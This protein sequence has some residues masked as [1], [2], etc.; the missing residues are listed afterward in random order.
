MNAN[1]ITK[2][3]VEIDSTLLDAIRSFPP[4]RTIAHCGETFTLSPFAFYAECPKCRL[5][6][7]VRSFAATPELEDVFDAVFEWM[8]DPQ[9][10][11]FAEQRR[12]DLAAEAD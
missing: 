4:F 11:A 5:R 2:N 9:A 7:K 10:A 8:T 6:M 1:T 12:K 3:P